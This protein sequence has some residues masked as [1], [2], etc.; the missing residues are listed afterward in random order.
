MVGGRAL[1]RNR[2]PSAQNLWRSVWRSEASSPAADVRYRISPF[3]NATTLGQP[4]AYRAT[5]SSL[6][7]TPPSY[8]D[9]NPTVQQPRTVGP[10]RQASLGEAQS[11]GPVAITRGAIHPTRLDS[12]SAC[13]Y[14]HPL[15]QKKCKGT[16]SAPELACHAEDIVE[17]VAITVEV[18]HTG[19]AA[20]RYGRAARTA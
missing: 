2:T 12:A 15:P 7:L 11:A 1:F 19:Q 14:R 5:G 10:S 17:R 20:R 6:K 8:V 16:A 18:Q 3:G 4:P 9:G 13:A